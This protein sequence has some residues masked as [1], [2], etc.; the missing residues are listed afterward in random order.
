MISINREVAK[1]LL[2]LLFPEFNNK[3]TW[4][5][6]LSGIALLSSSFIEQLFKL[7]IDKNLN[8]KL[9]G[10]SDALFGIVVI[11][12]GLCH[13]LA[14]VFL[15]RYHKDRAATEKIE[16][17]RKIF[18]HLESCCGEAELISHIEHILDTHN[19]ES[20]LS[21]KLWHF[22]Y[23]AKLIKNKFEDG[24]LNELKEDLV[25][26]SEEFDSFIGKEFF[27]HVSG[28]V[29]MR[30][31]WNADLCSPR[32]EQ[33]QSYDMLATE[34]CR[35]GCAVMEKYKCYRNLVKDRLLV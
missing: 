34:L 12:L 18:T 16:H 19:A 3:V 27:P 14:A 30:P 10:E 21:E 24:E 17:D 33:V 22:Q 7:L 11:A 29:R 5:V 35:L 28:M 13:N 2:K 4:A 25:C 32:E 26:A 9:T 31:D 1:K 20:G 15:N 6:V 8:L 23:E